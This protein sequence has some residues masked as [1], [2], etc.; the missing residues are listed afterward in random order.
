MSPRRLNLSIFGAWPWKWPEWS[1]EASIWQFSELDSIFGPLSQKWLEWASEGSFWT[2]S[3]PRPR[4]DQDVSRNLLL[5]LVAFVWR[6][7][8]KPAIWKQSQRRK[9]IQTTRQAQTQNQQRSNNYKN[10]ERQKQD[11]NDDNTH[12]R[13]KR[14]SKQEEAQGQ[15]GR[16]NNRNKRIRT[17]TKRKTTATAATAAA[18][19]TNMTATSAIPSPREQATRATSNSKS[20]KQQSDRETKNKIKNRVL[21]WQRRNHK[22]REIRENAY[23]KITFRKRGAR[24]DFWHD[25]MTCNINTKQNHEHTYEFQKKSRPWRGQLQQQRLPQQQRL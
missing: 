4:S 20:S 8:F 24:Q 14:P 10:K 15:R 11:W 2:F 13:D 5:L 1:P 7:K 6:G 21:Q 17:Q 16:N 3:G 23:K 22:L 9:Q 18:T 12:H 19:K 25:A